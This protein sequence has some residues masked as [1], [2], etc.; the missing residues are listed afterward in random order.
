MAS[1]WH[2]VRQAHVAHES[3]QKSRLR[4]HAIGV[5]ADGLSPPPRATQ[6][7][8]PATADCRHPLVPVYLGLVSHDAGAAVYKARRVAPP[9]PHPLHE[10]RRTVCGKSAARFVTQR[11]RSRRARSQTPT[12]SR[13]VQ[14]AGVGTERT[15]AAPGQTLDAADD[16]LALAPAWR[17]LGPP[18][19]LRSVFWAP[20]VI[21]IEKDF[22]A[23]Q[24]QRR[25]VD[26]ARFLH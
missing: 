26:C 24:G 16:L 3:R 1:R 2:P 21:V 20:Q 9:S 11:Q 14:G 6:K 15:A 18:A 8:S 23:D 22:A 17:D 12:Q 25:E 19:P 7:T 10:G 5:P 4:K 13:A